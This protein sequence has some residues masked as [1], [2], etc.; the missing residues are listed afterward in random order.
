MAFIGS[1]IQTIFVYLVLV[2]FTAFL[3]LM[4]SIIV[5]LKHQYTSQD[6][7]DNKIAGVVFSLMGLSIGYYL[8]CLVLLFT[9]GGFN[10][11]QDLQNLFWL[12]LGTIVTAV[13]G[14]ILKK[15]L[16]K[17]NNGNEDPSQIAYCTS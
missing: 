11:F 7:D 17:E 9:I 16:A 10:N 8:I 13:A 5:G 6:E 3:P 1:P 2:I 14:H 4:M 12:A 15:M